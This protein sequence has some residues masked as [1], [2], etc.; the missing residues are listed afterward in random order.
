MNI[1]PTCNRPIPANYENEGF[2]GTLECENGHVAQIII[3]RSYAEIESYIAHIAVDA[4]IK[5]TAYPGHGTLVLNGW[6]YQ[7]RIVC[8]SPS[9][10]TPL[11]DCAHCYASGP[12]KPTPPSQTTHFH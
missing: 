8:I 4:H 11:G 5:G 3:W 6:R 2:G 12:E 1:C 7:C 10:E 9:L